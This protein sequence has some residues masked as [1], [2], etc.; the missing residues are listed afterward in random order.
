MK[1]ENPG[2]HPAEIK[3]AGYSAD[4]VFGSASPD[5]ISLPFNPVTMILIT[6]ATGL[7]GAHLL[8][9][10]LRDGRAVRAIRREHSDLA[11]VRNLFRYYVP[12]PD[13]WLSKVEWV[14][15]DL[16]DNGSIGDALQ[17][18]EE[19]YHAA[20][21]VSFS[22]RDHQKM[23]KVNIE[24]TAG[25]VN[26]AIYSGV[27][28]F[29]HVSSIATLGRAEN[30][31]ISD[32]E[33]YWV[34]SPKNSVYSIS[35]YGAEREVWRG[36]EE[37]LRAVIINPSV[38]LGPGFWSGNSALFRLVDRGLKFYTR[39][40]NGYVDVRD[41]VKSLILLMNGNHFGERFVCSAGDLS[42]EELFGKM[43]GYL[44]KPRPM[45]YVPSAFSS[46]A[47]RLDAARALL[48]RTGP[49]ITR[50]LATTAYQVY[51]YSS[52]KLVRAIPFTFTSLDETI[53]E[54]CRHYRADHHQER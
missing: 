37:G 6:G 17:G 29:A 14:Q 3:Q 54:V 13:E 46:L 33:T 34:P 32:E 50:E 20:A 8:L 40:V 47:W 15:A 23:L 44:E 42:Y 51:R 1:T 22:H 39:G 26:Q 19:V 43:A 30:D 25:L 5:F 18:V 16:L 9:E 35:K 27:K 21:L 4:S 28:K 7:L 52:A 45:F 10:L 2:N 31:G 41:V 48:T 53:K 24:G 38:I 12:D 11:R 36:M 49:V